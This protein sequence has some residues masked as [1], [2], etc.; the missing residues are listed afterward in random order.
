MSSVSFAAYRGLLAE[1]ALRRLAI[2]DACARLPQGMVSIILLLVAA[3]HASMAVAGLV[4][5]GYTLGQAVTGPVRGRLADR[6]GLVPVAA[7]CGAAYLLAL[8]GLLA[9]ALTGAPAGLLIGA[10]ALAGLVNPPLSPGMR[11]LWSAAAG[12]RFAQ[13]AF[14]LDAAIFDLAPGTGLRSARPR[15]ADCW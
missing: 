4:V 5:A 13:A 7:S 1:P 10:A 14:A 9:G 15:W 2:A 12:A 3:E 8:L 6:Y 11:S